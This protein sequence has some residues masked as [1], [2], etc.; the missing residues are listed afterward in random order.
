MLRVFLLSFAIFTAST[1]CFS[2]QKPY[3]QYSSNASVAAKAL[4]SEEEII[5][6]INGTNTPKSS[7]KESLLEAARKFFMPTSIQEKYATLLKVMPGMLTNVKL[8]EAIDDWYG[9]RYRFGGTN[10]SGIDCSA[11]VRAVYKTA[12]GIDLP[13]TAREQYNTS[14][15]MIA[16]AALQAGDLLFFNTRGGV[17][18]VGVYLGNNKFAHASSSN[19][20]IVSSL[21]D[22][23]YAARYLGA[24]RIDND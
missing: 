17:S 16:A 1:N 13:R 8:L 15:H 11:F 10:K 3:N 6:E 2:Q 7:A 21:E 23:Y 9:T 5:A 22:K 14:H 24:K 12:F 18:H 4:P 19:G 20:V